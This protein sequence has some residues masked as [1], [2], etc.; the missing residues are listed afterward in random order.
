MS[1]RMNRRDPATLIQEAI[2]QIRVNLERV[3]WV[4]HEDLDTFVFVNIPGFKVYYVRNDVYSRDEAVLED[5]N[6]AFKPAGR[7]VKQL[8]E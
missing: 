8:V 3:R 2:E 6:A 7:L 4:L 1:T 5:L